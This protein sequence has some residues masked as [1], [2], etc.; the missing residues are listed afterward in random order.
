MPDLPSLLSAAAA[1]A[2]PPTQPEFSSI[3]E[4][5]SRRATRRRTA[6]VLS[7]AAVVII[8]SV[9]VAQGLGGGSGPASPAASPCV[10]PYANS[11]DDVFAA[12]PARGTARVRL[13]V[14]G[15]LTVGWRTCGESGSITSDDTRGVLNVTDAGSTGKGG[16]QIDVRYLAARLGRAIITGKGSAGS[17]GRLEVTVAAEAVSEP[18]PY[19]SAS[20]YGS[21]ANVCD[22]GVTTDGQG[23]LTMTASWDGDQN[24]LV[25]A[26]AVQNRMS[27]AEAIA[28]FRQRYYRGY[29]GGHPR[30]LFGLLTAQMPANYRADGTQTPKIVRRPVWLVVVCDGVPFRGYG[31]PIPLM[32][33]P[34]PG[35]SPS[36]G[37][38][39]HGIYLAPIDDHTQLAPYFS[40]GGDFPSDA[41]LAERFVS[42]PFTRD[43]RDSA[44][45]RQIGI[46]YSASGTCSTFD[47][48][49]LSETSAAVRVQVWLRL[50]NTPCDQSTHQAVVGLRHA[51]GDRALVRGD[52]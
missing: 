41:L 11:S 32:P 38:P 42:V 1:S 35:T 10:S 51:L 9:A 34:A 21:H 44:D 23:R 26:G 47:H 52:A 46:S 3:R 49:D 4:R 2:E 45:A 27:A 13:T 14:G 48:L 15:H 36:P 28:D 24:V 31:G 29:P 50:V 6:L 37:A 17:R 39:T 25:P 12:I 19:P 22:D 16:P 8:G 20:P 43:H 7:V 40:A 30:A 33:T 5:A 18:S